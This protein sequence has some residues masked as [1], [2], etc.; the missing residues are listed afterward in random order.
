MA[1]NPSNSHWIPSYTSDGTNISIPIASFPGLTAGE[2]HT[3]TGDIR[4]LLYSICEELN[5][6]W[7]AEAAADR[8]GKWTFVKGQSL[9]PATGQITVTYN[10]TFVL[11][12]ASIDVADES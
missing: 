4:K 12:P 10:F 7:N 2:A 1:F 3:T 9:N 5:T 8:P 11:Q 6:K